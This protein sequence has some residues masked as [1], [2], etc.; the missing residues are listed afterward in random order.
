M[1]PDILCER[2]GDIATVTLFNPDKLNAV[3]GAMWRRLKVVMDELDGDECLRC[4]VLRGEGGTFAAGGDLEEFLTQRDTFE[5]AQ[6]YHGEWV[7]G[8]LDS[9]VDC[10]HPSVA[11]IE[12]VCIGGGLEIASCCDLRIAGA[13]ARFGA[14]IMKLGFTM[15]HSELVG[16]VALAGPAVAL[17]ILLEGRILGAVEAYEKG[18]LTRVVADAEVAEE[19]YATARRIAAG[20]PMVARAHKKLVRRLMAQARALTESEVRDNFAF[21]DSTDYQEGLAAFLA[22]RKPQFQGH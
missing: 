17:E 4:V 22:K 18:L 10:R 7:A 12:G 14:P 3:N 9:I 16:L 13:G 15:A 20:A 1:N 5:R 19:A 8:A 6:V 11:L 2:D 21:L